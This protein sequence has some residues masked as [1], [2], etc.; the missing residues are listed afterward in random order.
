MNI[1]LH[2]QQRKAPMKYW[3]GCTVAALVAGTLV[4]SL[5]LA[6]DKPT[7][8]GTDPK[9]AELM[10]KAEA[11]SMPGLA[12]KRLEPLVGDWNVEAKCWMSPGAAP[13]ISKGNEKSSWVLNGRFIQQQ[14]TGEFMRKPFRGIG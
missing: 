1:Q 2:R 5:T 9:M 4:V 10:K 14:F 3:I 8:A 7:S 11:A 6:Q 13:L 12:H